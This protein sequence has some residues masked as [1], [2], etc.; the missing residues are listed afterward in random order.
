MAEYIQIEDANW[1]IP[2][3]G[4]WCEGYVE[5]AWGQAT[6]PTVK[7]PTT[8]GVWKTATYAWKNNYGNGNHPGELPPEGVTVPVFFSLG[9]TSDGHVAIKLSDGKVASTTQPG[10]HTE[11]YIH[12]N[13][14]DLINI[15]AKYNNGCTY[16][17]WSEYVG[18]KQVVKRKEDESMS[19]EELKWN[20]RLIGGYEPSQ[21]ELDYWKG[22]IN[23]GATFKQV[24]EE[25][26]TWYQQRGEGY[27]QYKDKTQQEID[28]LN[29]ELA[30]KPKEVIK[31]VPVDRIV[32]KEVIKGDEDRTFGDLLS[33][34]FKKLF[35]V[36]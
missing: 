35:N 10:F 22:R 26:K 6:L 5:G 20:Y 29:Q 24:T 4:G 12:P 9:S 8:S 3:V 34:A 36:K 11:G 33:A 18:K 2:Y 25:M 14:Q 17:G 27:Y 19:E 21:E 31:E 15:Y 13:L 23:G 1:R 7:N 30:E 32:E 16:L 28:Q